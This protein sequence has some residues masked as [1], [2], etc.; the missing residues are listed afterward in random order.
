MTSE[1]SSVSLLGHLIPRIASGG[2]EPAATKALTYILSSTDIAQA[3]VR[4]VGDTG[5]EFS[6]GRIVAEEKHGDD[7][8]DLTIRDTDD[9]VRVIVENKFWAGL[10]KAQPVAYLEALLDDKLS[11]LLFIVPHQRVYGLW[12]E[13]R[14]RCSDAK[15]KLGSESRTSA[16]TWARADQRVLAITSWKH[17]LETLKSAADGHSALQQDIDQLRGLTDRMD[18]DAFLPL[19]EDEV[20]DLNGARRLIN[21]SDLIEPIV[22]RLVTDGIASTKSAVG[23][24]HLQPTHGWYSA[25]RYLRVHT[26]FGLWLGVDL[27]AWREWGITPIWSEHDTNSDFC[28]VEGRIWQAKE[29]FDDAQADGSLLYIPIRLTTGADRDRVIDDAAQQMRSIADRFR[30]AFPDE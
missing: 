1:G 5:A 2:V 26:K 9:V 27:K 12:G 11:V 13:L 15:I 3:F 7:I 18:V 23:S 20:T 8:P 19:R 21:Y 25:G 14:K 16:I 28:G 4:I 24:G 22:D 29:L 10:T 17:V 6:P 30:K